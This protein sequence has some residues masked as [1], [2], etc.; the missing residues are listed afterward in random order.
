MTALPLRARRPASLTEVVRSGL[1]S[2]CGLCASLAGPGKITMGLNMKG[3]SRPLVVGE[4]DE[5]THRTILDVCPGATLTGP[6]RPAGAKTHPVWGP[7]REIHR[8]W[9]AESEVRHHA[10]AGGTLSGLGRYLIDSG[11]VDAILHVRASAK[12]PWLT[13]ATVSRNADDVYGGAQSR[14]GPSAPL[15]HVKQLLDGGERFAVVAKPCDISA[16]RALA[17]VDPRVD[18]QVRFL[19]TNFC[20]GVFNAQVARAMIRFHGVEES[21]VDTF[22]FRGDGWPGPHRVQAKDGRTFDLSYESAYKDRPWGYDMQFRCKICPDGV[23]ESADISVPDAWIL[24]DGRPVYDEAPGVNVAVVRTERGRDLLARAVEAGYLELS[25]ISMTELEQMHGNHPARKV[26]APA[27]FTA[28][29]VLGQPAPRVTGYR[30]LASVLRAG[31]RVS[32]GQFAG[33][34]RRVLKRD[35]REPVI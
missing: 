21:E 9:S 23:G 32:W 5:R 26:G 12:T 15:V 25:S 2:G 13:E 7:I 3:N 16:V 24:K 27:T 17:R 10:A 35:N 31:W 11:E 30:P 19:L 8:V 20:G 28:L 6:G 22:R 1:C 14:Y 33:T 18:R 4:L 29:R 34:V